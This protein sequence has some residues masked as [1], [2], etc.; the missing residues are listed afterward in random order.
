MLEVALMKIEND[1]QLFLSHQ[2]MMEIF[3]EIADTVVPFRTY[4]Q[5]MFE[6]KLTPTL[7]KTE[8]PK[9]QYD[10]AKVIQMDQLTCELFFPSREENKDTTVLATSMAVIMAKCWLKELRDPK[11]G[12]LNYLT[13]V[14][15]KFSWGNTSEEVHEAFLGKY[16]TNDTAET[17]FARPT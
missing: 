12:T 2:F 5:Y 14:D 11:K 8:T 3:K 17:P 9:A 13:S 10:A 6:E 15:G 7:P 4:I 1:G 16:T